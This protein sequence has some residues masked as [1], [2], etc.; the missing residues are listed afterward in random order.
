MKKHLFLALIYILTLFIPGFAQLPAVV[1][2]TE[3]AVFQI[4]TFNE[5]GVTFSS[6]TGFFIDKNGTCITAWHVLEEAKFAFIE[7][8]A[9]NKYRIKKITRTNVDAD[10]VEFILDTRKNDFPFIPL[11]S[12]LPAKGTEVFT[13]G[14]PV[15]YKNIVSTGIISGYEI[16]DST[17]TIETS[18][19]ISSGSS[20]GPLMNM[21]GH[22][23][24]VIRSSYSTAQNLN[25]A[26]SIQERKKMKNDSLTDL[27]SDI[28]GNFYMLN[29]KSKYDQ[30]LTLN[31]IELLDSMTVF[32]FSYVNLSITRGN[33]AYVYCNTKNRDET[34]FIQEKDSITKHYIKS[35]SLSETIEDAPTIKLGQVIHFNLFFDRIKSLKNFDL[36]ENMKG[37][38]WSFQDITIPDKTYLTSEMFDTYNKSQ[39]HETSTKLRRE[40]FTEAKSDI[41]KLRNSI[42]N[43][44]LL[45]QLSAITSNSLG[46]FDE[47]IESINNLIKLNPTNAD[48][49][50][51]LYTVYLNIDSTAKALEN[52]NKA[53][54]YNEEYAYYFYCRGELN[55]KLERWKES[56]ADYNEYLRLR[57]DDIASVYLSRGI[58]KAMIKDVGACSDLEKAKDLAESDREWEKIN[59][60]YRKYCK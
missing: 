15:G 46:K 29:I 45:E 59:K 6:G 17:K 16:I 33:D 58:A 24:G 43:N 38:N 50:A 26:T 53:I 7:D 60:E 55:F 1:A 13:I 28:N 42:K 2:K 10:I 19:P 51:D 32:N 37:S 34:F 25:F 8:H 56:I 14:N 30:K 12:I 35:S 5:Y 39:F 27:M 3:K 4:E 31:S 47:A 57:K 41:D 40:E 52:I 44:E 23:I 21:Q 49:Y 18:T 22:A 36:K 11:A 20:G 9:G 54:Q 48:Y